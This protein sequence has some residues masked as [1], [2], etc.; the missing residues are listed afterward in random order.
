MRLIKKILSLISVP[1]FIILCMAVPS[2]HAENFYIQNYEVKLEVNEKKLVKVEEEIEVYFLQPSHGIIREIPH[3]KASVTNIRAQGKNSVDNYGGTV[4]I[5]LGSADKTVSGT[6]HYHITYNFNYRDNKSEFYHNIIGPEW[7]V[8]V[9]KA[10]F[11]LVMPKAI[12][13][14]KAG[15]SMG[16]IDA[17]GFESGAEYSITDNIKI[18]GRTLRELQPGEGI[19]FRVEVPPGYFEKYHPYAVYIAVA[20]LSLLAIAS[21]YIWNRYGKDDHVTPVVTFKIPSGVN[22]VQAELAYKGRASDK[23]LSALLVE[24]ANKDYVKIDNKSDSFLIEKIKPFEQVSL[25]Q[26]YMNALF[27]NDSSV[28]RSQIEKS[29]TYY[30]KCRSIVAS[31]NEER[32]IIYDE[33]TIKGRLPKIMAGIISAV[34]FVSLFAFCDFSISTFISAE[35]IGPVALLFLFGTPFVADEWDIGAK[36]SLL[37]SGGMIVFVFFITGSSSYEYLNVFVFGI[38]CLAI[39]WICADNLP[40]RSPKGKQLMSELQGLRK[41]IMTAEKYEL[42][43]MAEKDPKHF[44]DILPYAFVL[45]VSDVWIKKLNKFLEG[46]PVKE[47]PAYDVTR[48]SRFSRSMT[49]LSRPSRLNGGIKKTSYHGSSH[50]GGGR[51]GRGGGGGGGRSW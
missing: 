44:Y 20:L 4:E 47:R 10:S 7:G 32:K 41:F 49:A 5:K 31:A 25:E 23:G 16:G 19:T 30:K 2:V 14:E 13:P 42:E 22:A 51:V 28:T 34:I 46:R 38:A 8:P 43:A 26:E 15:I 18:E 37:I 24:L 21:C 39:S 11:T 48:L 6:H 50:G 1:V 9:K 12:D 29:Q 45:D 40:K 17:A 3:K 35:T 33:K 27:G 36:L